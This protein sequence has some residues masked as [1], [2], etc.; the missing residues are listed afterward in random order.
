MTALLAW[1]TFL[2]PAVR[3][4]F[5]ATLLAC[6]VPSAILA[7]SCPP[8]TREISRQQTANKITLRCACV[9]GYVQSSNRCITVDEAA[10]GNSLP[11]D[12]VDLF[13]GAAYSGAELRESAARN[14]W[15]VTDVARA[16]LAAFLGESG[17][18]GPAEVVIQ[19]I[20]PEAARHPAVI[21]A[22]QRIE[23]LR[24]KEAQQFTLLWPG[25]ARSVQELAIGH[26]PMKGRAA[27]MVGAASFRVGQYE[28]ALR[29]L[30]DAQEVVP[31]DKGIEEALVFVRAVQSSVKDK[32]DPD[33]AR[34]RYAQAFRSAGGQAAWQLGLQLISSGDYVGAELTLRE[35]RDRLA[36]LPDTR[37]S[38][39]EL[40]DKLRQ[41]T[42]TDR[43]AGD[44]SMVDP[45][46][47]RMFSQ[48]SKADL[49]FSALEYGQKDWA[50]SL[51][52]LE[53]AM[54]ADPENTRIRQA[55]LELKEIA[56]SVK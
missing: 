19:I 11:D 31:G 15:P 29:Y 40:I 47:K 8:N 35:A 32:S 10:S 33:A 14:P 43:E 4:G 37:T 55:Y 38:E 2:R 27:F 46:G 39:V 7:Q 48:I 26:M 41:K 23:A 6:C 24:R 3:Q 52:Y 21:A 30:K 36:R 34:R 25:V 54:H 50:R 44:R 45:P 5:V 12:L 56:A 9:V 53:V 42:R 28:Q 1:T 17:A 49:M 20:G 22:K 51:H 13:T 16:V 18:F